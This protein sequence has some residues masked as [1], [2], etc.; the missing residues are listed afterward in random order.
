MTSITRHRSS[1]SAGM[2]RTGTKGSPAPASEWTLA[3]VGEWLRS[4]VAPYYLVLVS[5]GLLT[6]LGLVMVLS[7]SSVRSYVESGNSYTVFLE[8]VAFAGMG[9]LMAFVGARQIPTAHTTRKEEIATKA[10]PLAAE[11]GAVRAVAGRVLHNKFEAG[12]GDVLTG[13]VQVISLGR[14]FEDRKSVV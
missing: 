6:G 5:A 3:S 13:L 9:L 14:L 1:G 2:P 4:P 12:H 10:E 11:G 8:Q 7:A